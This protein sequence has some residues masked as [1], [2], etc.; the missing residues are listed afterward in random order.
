[1]EGCYE[2]HRTRLGAWCQGLEGCSGTLRIQRDNLISRSCIN[3]LLC[4][5]HPRVDSFR[6]VVF[7][8]VRVLLIVR[9]KFENGVVGSAG[10][11]TAATGSSGR[12]RQGAGQGQ[13]EVILP[14]MSFVPSDVGA[15]GGLVLVDDLLL[16]QS[17]FTR[18]L[19]SFCCPDEYLGYLNSR[20]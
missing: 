18:L 10:A 17:V 14:F 4:R 20:T 7:V 9:R 2:H 11:G 1:V 3:L 16:S 6:P 19:R 15:G 13:K 12:T 8:E 5:S